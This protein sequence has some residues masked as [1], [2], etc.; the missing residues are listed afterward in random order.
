MTPELERKIREYL[1][2]ESTEKL[3]QG[4]ALNKRIKFRA[5]QILRSFGK[6]RSRITGKDDLSLKAE[7]R[8]IATHKDTGEVLFDFTKENLITDD[9]R[10]HALSLLA[11]ATGTVTFVAMA[12]GDDDGSSLALAAT[13]VR[14]GN[15]LLGNAQRIACTDSGGGSFATGDVQS[16]V[17]GS[18]RKYLIWQAIFPEG[19]G[20]NGSNF[21]E[22]ALMS[23]TTLPGTPTTQSGTMFNRII[24]DADIPKT[25]QFILTVQV[26]VRA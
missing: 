21:R 23:T 25:D 5:K 22:L 13:N 4:T 15:E 1:K 19:D 7:W 26:K 24:L 18:N 10:T 14:L 20:N 16:E 12:V 9:G 2:M 3:P 17:S 8:F 6:L 11:G